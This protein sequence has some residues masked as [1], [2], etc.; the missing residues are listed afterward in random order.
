MNDQIKYTPGDWLFRVY[1]AGFKC[2]CMECVQLSIIVWTMHGI[3]YI[4]S[5]GAHFPAED[6][7]K[8]KE[9]A[10]AEIEKKEAA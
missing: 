7:F 6:T 9:E 3:Y 10:L 8:T 4:D 5:S 2:W 1:Q